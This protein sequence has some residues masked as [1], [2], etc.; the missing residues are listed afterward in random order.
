MAQLSQSSSVVAIAT[1]LLLVA[2]QQSA[3]A[4]MR[5]C[6]DDLERGTSK[7]I[8]CTFPIKPSA[9]EKLELEKQTKG[10][11]KDATCSVAIR[12][13]RALI[14][15]AIEQSDFVFQA[16]PQPVTCEV[17]AHIRKVGV[18]PITGTFSPRVVF[19]DGQAVEATP[20]LANV[21]GVTSVISW[22]V[23]T[24]VNRGGMI[25]DG[26]LQVVNAWLGHMRKSKQAA[27]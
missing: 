16:P 20:G 10:V 5:D 3:A 14:R 27:N 23:V 4:D 9:A 2:C 18:Y 22:P 25:R 11:L 7:D 1:A 6:F 24:Y 19:K 15:T 8:A 21:T 17:T 26:M 13:E 12:I